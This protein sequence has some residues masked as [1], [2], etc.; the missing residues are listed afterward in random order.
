MLNVF[1]PCPIRMLDRHV[2]SCGYAL[3]ITDDARAV[4]RQIAPEVLHGVNPEGGQRFAKRRQGLAGTGQDEKRPHRCQF[5]S[6]FGI[7]ESQI[8][9]LTRQ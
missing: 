1:K 8:R 9:L 4:L 2:A 6:H 7:W 5:K 3:D